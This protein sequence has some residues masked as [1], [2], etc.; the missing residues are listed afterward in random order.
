VQNALFRMPLADPGKLTQLGGEFVLAPGYTC[1]FAHRM[2]NTSSELFHTFPLPS[3]H[4]PPPFHSLAPRVRYFHL[5][6]SVFLKP[7][8]R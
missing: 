8:L 6:R 2:T 4:L 3:E 7:L 1:E 5:P